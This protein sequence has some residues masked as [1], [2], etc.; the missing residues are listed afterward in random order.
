[1]SVWRIIAGSPVQEPSEA[2]WKETERE[3]FL[4]AMRIGFNN[5]VESF[6][7]YLRNEDVTVSF[8]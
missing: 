6:P 4:T 8:R 3:P 1:M 7:L 5:P 2:W